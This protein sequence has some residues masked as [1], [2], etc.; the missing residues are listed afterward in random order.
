LYV[1]RVEDLTALPWNHLPPTPRPEG[2]AQL[3]ARFTYRPRWKFDLRANG[4]GWPGWILAI[5]AWVEDTYKPGQ[6]GKV[7]TVLTVPQADMDEDGWMRWLHDYAVRAVEQHETD[8]WFLIDG[9]RPWDP[10]APGVKPSYTTVRD[11][12]GRPSVRPAG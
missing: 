12:A 9:R 5:T 2:L 3:L 4:T 7:M 1:G 6:W 8:E 10:H 11:E